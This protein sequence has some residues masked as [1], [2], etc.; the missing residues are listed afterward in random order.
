M[1]NQEW[2]IQRHKQHWAQ[3]TGQRQKNPPQKT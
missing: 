1:G 3:D 2:T